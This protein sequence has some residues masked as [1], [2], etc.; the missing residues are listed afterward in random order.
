MPRLHTLVA[1]LLTIGC[2]APAA[3]EGVRW[4]DGETFTAPK[5]MMT[6]KPEADTP[7]P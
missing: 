7:A 3:D 4:V 1:T 6:R 2:A 5:Q